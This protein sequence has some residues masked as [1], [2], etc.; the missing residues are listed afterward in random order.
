MSLQD[1]AQ[2]VLQHPEAG[3]GG[4][5]RAFRGLPATTPA[6]FLVTA[7][8]LADQPL[9]EALGNDI[10][11]ALLRL[12]PAVQEFVP[13]CSG[14]GY[15][16]CH[17]ENEPD[18]IK[19]LLPVY[20]GSVPA[21]F[22]LQPQWQQPTA[23]FRIA[24]VLTGNTPATVLP[25]ALSALNA[26]RWSPG[27]PTAAIDILQLGDIISSRRRMFISYVRS[28]CDALAEQLF[29]GL[30][31]RGFDVFLDRFRLKPGVD[32]Q[33]RL[34]EEL[35]QM[36]TVLVLESPNIRKSKWVSHEVNFARKYNIGLTALAL[37]G[38]VVVPGIAQAARIPL[39]AR[40]ISSRT[41]RL[42][43]SRLQQVIA[44]IE[45]VH[46]RTERLRVAYLRDNLSRALAMAGFM[47]QG[48]D[49]NGTVVARNGAN[50]YAFRVC[51]LPAELADFQSID[52]YRPGLR[53]AFVVA[54]SHFM[55]WRT[56]TPLNWLT[57]VTGIR[58]K[59]HADMPAE[60]R[61]LP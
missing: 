56:R 17:A 4:R 12:G 26:V 28:D 11:H 23:T 53:E 47:S 34:N 24:P 30:G 52:R 37:P 33:V 54:P 7:A 8:S 45:S 29:D 13:P 57:G 18:C 9:A 27:S 31:R 50:E 15:G 25:P 48:F 49:A 19:L 22:I 1:G 2:V 55:N 39:S 38:G 16:N 60:L 3:S 61:G 5:C 35:S 6:W 20:S 10:A 40:E 42:R 59:D 44:Q 36:G 46:A 41:R 58:L 51:N 14:H 32:F 43:T 21:H